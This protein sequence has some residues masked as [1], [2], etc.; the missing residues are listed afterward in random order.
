MRQ[1]MRL[2]ALLA[3]EGVNPNKKYVVVEELLCR[4]VLTDLVVEELVLCQEVLT[5]SR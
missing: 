3:W 5:G 2:S 4:E 1:K